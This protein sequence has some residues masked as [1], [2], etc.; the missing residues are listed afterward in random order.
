MHDNFYLKC[1]W[2]GDLNGQNREDYVRYMYEDAGY[3]V[4]RL[5]SSAKKRKIE[6]TL[7]KFLWHSID[8]M[9]G[10]PDF[11]VLDKKN[12]K[13]FFLEVKHYTG[14]L[15]YRQIQWIMD[16]PNVATVVLFIYDEK[17]FYLS[18]R[19]TIEE[20]TKGFELG[21]ENATSMDDVIK[22]IKSASE[23]GIVE[24]KTKRPNMV[25]K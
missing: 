11:L 19:E 21:L 3:E 9:L 23:D 6:N 8:S 18:M 14:G 13:F 25:N 15:S 16:H 4:V 5:H 17:E 12:K 7:P 10:I 22:E 20:E 24:I 1:H 2:G